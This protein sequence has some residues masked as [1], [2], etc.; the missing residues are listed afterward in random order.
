MHLLEGTLDAVAMVGFAQRGGAFGEVYTGGLPVLDPNTDTYTELQRRHAYNANLGYLL[1]ELGARLTPAREYPAYIRITGALGIPLVQPT[2]EQT[3]EI[4]SPSGVLYPETNQAIRVVSSGEI[5]DVGPM[6]SVGGAIG[7]P[8]PLGVRTTAAPEISYYHPLNDVTSSYPWKVSTLQIGLAVRHDFGRE[9]TPPPPPPPPQPPPPP[10]PPSPKPPQ[11]AVAAV[12]AQKIE[13][14]ETLV[15]ETFPILP[16]I[17]FDSAGADLLAR[18]RRISPGETTSFSE[19]D[20]PH[21]SLGAYYDLLNVIGGR[22]RRLPDARITLNGATDGREVP[23]AT[24][25]H[26][27]ARRRAQEVRDYLVEVWGIAPG[28]IIISGTG[29]PSFPSN[30]EYQEGSQEN[31]RVEIR[32]TNDAIL[33]PIVFERFSEYGVAP[34]SIPLS[35]QASSPDGIESWQLDVYAG[36]TKVW[37]QRGSGVPPSTV[38]WNLE[39]EVAARVARSLALGDGE[40]RCELSAIAGSGAA[41][42]DD[43]AQPVRRSMS[44]FEVSRLSL[45]VF[46]FDKSEISQQNRRMVSTFV[47]KSMLS[48]SKATIVGSTDRLGEL[49]HNQELSEARAFAVRDLIRS[50]QPAAEITKVEGIGPSRLLHDNNIPEGRYYCRTV[51]VE[52]RTPIEVK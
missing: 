29:L 13:I 6:L 37:E 27:L 18:Y 51:T 1:S 24:E 46:D 4:L 48:S 40:L 15:T 43:F 36:G 3:E 17:F 22:M 33:Q 25:S 21:R 19:K 12:A 2:H 50:Q 30:P 45:I 31:R 49:A 47:S 23:S 32:A 14:E 28:R 11:V 42:S 44:P 16:Y 34:R 41:A 7:Y 35:L 20:L 9:P 39:S 8:F 38:T 52:V 5:L 26:Q 10:P